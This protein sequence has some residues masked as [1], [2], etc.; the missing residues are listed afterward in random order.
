MDVGGN[1]PAE[2]FIQ[3][4]VLGGGGQVLAAPHH[5]G[6]VHQVVV[7]D[8]GEVVG[9]VA[10]RLEEHLVLDLLVLN[11]DGAEHRVLKGGGARQGHLLPDD[12]RRAR[13]QQPLDLL[14]GQI[15]AVPVVAADALLVVQG[16]QPLLGA[17]AVIG[18]ALLH[19]LLGV[20]LVQILALALDVGAVGAAHVRAL[21]VLQAHL[22]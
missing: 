3:Q 17:E 13:V 1:L 11:G 14:L 8:V 2:G 18:L 12:V 21:V 6:D 19:Q 9:G 15:P 22:L 4:V 10:V 16:F 20:G 5:V 7:D